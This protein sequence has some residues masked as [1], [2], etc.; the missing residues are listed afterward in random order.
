MKNTLEV[1]SGLKAEGKLH[2]RLLIQT[3]ILTAVSLAL[4][5]VVV[6]QVI[7]H[8]LNSEIA[9]AISAL[10]FALGVLVFSKMNKLVWN[11]EDEV[12]QTGKMELMGFIIL[13]LYIAFEI[14]LRTILNNEFAGTFAA[15]AY[16][17]AG[18]GSSLLGRSLGTLVAI[19]K[20]DEREGISDSIHVP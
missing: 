8:G 12:I 10:G 4:L 19:R 3:R 14:G 15:M 18:I 1:V 13:V 2:K 11:E 20:L 7:V 9:L 17:F 6:Y 5:S 16:L